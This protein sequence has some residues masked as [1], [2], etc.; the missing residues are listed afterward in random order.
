M[1]VEDFEAFRLAQHGK[2]FLI[3][4]PKGV[5]CTGQEMRGCGFRSMLWVP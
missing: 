2:P 4:T 3:L 1:P 5:A